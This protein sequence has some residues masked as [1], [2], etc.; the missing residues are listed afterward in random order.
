MCLNNNP[1]TNDGNWFVVC[2]CGFKMP[3]SWGGFYL[4]K[5]KQNEAD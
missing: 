4:D 3:R 1:D 5:E 2:K